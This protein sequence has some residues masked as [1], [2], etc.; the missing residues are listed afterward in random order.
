M[1]KINS[2]TLT[3]PSPACRRNTETEETFGESRVSP[4]VEWYWG[5]LRGY[6]K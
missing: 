3:F 2:I 5:S 1:K 4:K 6:Q